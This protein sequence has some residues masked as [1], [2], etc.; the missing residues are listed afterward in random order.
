[1]E[2]PLVPIQRENKDNPSLPVKKGWISMNGLFLKKSSLEELSKVDCITVSEK[3]IYTIIVSEN[4]FQEERE[5]LEW[6]YTQDMFNVIHYI[7]EEA[8]HFTVYVPDSDTLKE[9]LDKISS[10]IKKGYVPFKYAV[11]LAKNT[12]KLRRSLSPEYR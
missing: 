7:N 3:G 8:G 10:H 1:M 5:R 9:I 12:E 4:R 2:S 6:A 11:A